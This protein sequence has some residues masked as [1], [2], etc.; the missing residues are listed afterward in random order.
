MHGSLDTPITVG[1]S[2]LRHSSESFAS[3]PV[4][5]LIRLA[6]LDA[7]AASQIV[8]RDFPKITTALGP[9][10]TSGST[11]GRNEFNNLR[12]LT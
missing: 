2:S 1:P 8:L 11:I 12:P 3:D 4:L 6:V 9:G 10:T 5:D 7:G